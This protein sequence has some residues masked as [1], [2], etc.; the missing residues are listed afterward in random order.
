MSTRNGNLEIY[1]MNGDGS[2]QVRLTDNTILDDFPH[3]K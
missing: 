2:N 3:I 1:L